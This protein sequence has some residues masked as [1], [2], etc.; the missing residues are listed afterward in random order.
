MRSTTAVNKRKRPGIP[1]L[2]VALIAMTMGG[3]AAS[4]AAQASPTTWRLERTANMTGPNGALTGVSCAKASA[5]TAVGEAANTDG[6]EVTLAE[7]W[8]GTGWKTQATPSPAG[9]QSSQ[10]LGVSCT[11]ASACTA[12][13]SSFN[14]HGTEVTLAEV[15]NGSVWRIRTTPNPRGS[16]A[17][18]LAAVSCATATACTAVGEETKN[19]GTILTVAEAWNG[20]GWKIQPTPNP[21]G[22]SGLFG[23]S[24]VLSGVSC[25][26]RTACTAVGDYLSTSDSLLGLVEGWNGAAWTIQK[27]PSPSGSIYGSLS[28]VSCHVGTCHA[29]GDYYSDR[30]SLQAPWAEVRNG[31]TWKAQTVPSPSDAQGSSL[32]GVSCPTTSACTAIGNYTDSRGAEVPL[33]E[34]GHGT[35]WRIQSSPNPKGADAS[36]FSGVSCAAAT[37]VAAG[38]QADSS[39]GPEMTLGEGSSGSTW[40]VQTTRDPSGALSSTLSGVSCTATTAC[41][42][43]GSYTDRNGTPRAMA[44]RWN[45]KT[46]KIQTVPTPAGAQQSEL[47]GVSCPEASAC[48]AIGSYTNSHGTEVTLAEVGNGTSWKVQTTLDPAGAQ[49]SHLAGVSCA[50]ATAC[51]AVGG[52]TNSGGIDEMM[53]EVWNGGHWQVEIPNPGGDGSSGL[54]GVSCT[55]PLACSAVGTYVTNDGDTP[56]TLAEVQVGTTWT[57]ESTPNPSGD[58]QNSLAAVSC[59]VRSAC[60]AGGNTD[61]TA[62]AEAWNGSTWKLQSTPMPSGAS[63]SG[64]SGMSCPKPTAC[65]AVGSDTNDADANLALVEVWN[66]TS[67]KIQNTPAAGAPH[68]YLDA[69]SCSASTACTAVGSS[70]PVGS[71]I[72]VTLAE[73]S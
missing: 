69:V 32:L 21:A 34:D 1:A 44:E 70:T 40:K 68:T 36:T 61:G 13:G 18:S 24:S 17:T 14:R 72:E 31:N 29:V 8:N 46:W 37:C 52:Y 26:A 2:L 35:T 56:L 59:P 58:D 3:I 45:G 33:I 43:V 55:G 25:T 41:T 5:C 20:S 22:G 19:A 15:W 65:T 6:V 11:K 53:A 64:L 48:T 28:A 10:L 12:V 66:G 30:S 71:N 27:A 7:V 50:A 63:F 23:H 62:L 57:S 9:A 4:P 16:E 54:A 39:G 38:K 42:A 67:W 51:T 47:A 49:A 60:A 73:A